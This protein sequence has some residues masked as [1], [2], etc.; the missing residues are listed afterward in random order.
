[1][2]FARR[3]LP[4]G[5]P[6]GKWLFVTWHLRGSLPHRRYPPPGKAHTSKRLDTIV[7]TAD[8]SVRATIGKH[9]PTD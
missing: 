2:A 4:H 9:L 5:Y 8:T 6:Q 3:R 7:E 1:M